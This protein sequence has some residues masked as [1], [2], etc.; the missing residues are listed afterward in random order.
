[1]RFELRHGLPRCWGLQTPYQA[2]EQDVEQCRGGGSATDGL[3]PKVL[4]EQ[5]RHNHRRNTLRI[6]G[7]GRY[8]RSVRSL[9]VM[10]SNPI[11]MAST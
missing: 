2:G 11:A 1:M 7:T 9:L 8:V 6:K 3:P 10:A 4:V 5:R